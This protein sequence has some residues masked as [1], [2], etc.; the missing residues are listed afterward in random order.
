MSKHDIVGLAIL[1]SI[2]WTVHLHGPWYSFLAVIAVYLCW[3][4][5][6]FF[7]ALAQHSKPAKQS[8]G[9]DLAK[10]IIREGGTRS[11]EIN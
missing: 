4:A 5:G 3:I 1:L 11:K 8:A 7:L 2:I 10:K 9:A 6:I